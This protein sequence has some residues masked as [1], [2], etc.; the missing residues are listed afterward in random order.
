MGLDF[1][2]WPVE[3]VRGGV[4]GFAFVLLFL[5]A[6]WRWKGRD[7]PDAQADIGLD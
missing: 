2:G 4:A 5:A 1:L 7:D 3:L 6:R